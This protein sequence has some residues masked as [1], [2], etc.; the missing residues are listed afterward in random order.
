MPNT[1]LDRIYTWYSDLRDGQEIEHTAVL[2][3][4]FA[5]ELYSKYEPTNGPHP[6]FWNRLDKW[7][8]KKLSENQQKILFRLIPQIF[9]VGEDEIKSLYRVAFNVSIARWLIDQLNITFLDPN[10]E[11]RLKNAA[12]HTW[13][14]PITDSLKINSFYHV[15]NLS[16][17][18]YRPDWQ[19]LAELQAGD[20]V[21]E[22]VTRERI[23]RIVLLEDFVGS[24][25]QIYDAIDF[26]CKLPINIPLLAVPLICCEE[27]RKL[28]RQFE[29]RFSHF[30]FDS[31]L[32]IRSQDC[33]MEHPVP[34]ESSLF[35]ELRQVV[36]D[37]FPLV[38]SGLDS[39]ELAKLQDGPFGFAS[40]GSLVVLYT[41][42]PDNTLPLIHQRSDAW[43][44]LFPRA[45]RL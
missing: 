23:E 5:D 26:A 6:D 12:D 37:S 31:V 21:I 38:T 19:S 11:A 17:R 3:Q 28:G 41:N 18:P 16:G 34:G 27:G 32:T 45:S 25:S 15:N 44:P 2:V 7:L 40:T 4:H 43:W 20:K 22:F 14:C 24:G 9:F 36:V 29:A 30:S 8:N 39:S 35:A 13:F 1:V 10:A 42:C 33:L